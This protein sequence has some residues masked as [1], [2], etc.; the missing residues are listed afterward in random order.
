MALR[1]SEL[2]SMRDALLAARFKC[3]RTIRS[4]EGDEITYRSDAEMAAA[5]ADVERRIA[6]FSNPAPVS[7]V[8]VRTSK[9]L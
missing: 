4:A 5:L 9:G 6:R 2:E 1:L 3:V 8:R 7:Q